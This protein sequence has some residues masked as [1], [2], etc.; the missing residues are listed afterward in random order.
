MM[1]KF[2]NAPFPTEEE[3]TATEILEVLIE[4][5]IDCKIIFVERTNDYSFHFMNKGKE[6]CVLGAEKYHYPTR[7][8]FIL[9]FHSSEN[10]SKEYSFS[11]L[12]L[13]NRDSFASFIKS[14]SEDL[15]LYLDENKKTS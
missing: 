13:N 8:R 10:A 7:N 6:I 14:F 15:Q 5:G 3:Y 4:K 9:N 12:E 2:V 1:R 11:V